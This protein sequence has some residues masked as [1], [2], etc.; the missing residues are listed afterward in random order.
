[1]GADGRL[2]V[3]A[4]VDAAGLQKLRDLLLKYEEILKLMKPS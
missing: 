2:Q 1:M 4:N 3:S